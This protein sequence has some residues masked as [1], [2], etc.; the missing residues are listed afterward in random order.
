MNYVWIPPGHF[1][2]GC[3]NCSYDDEKPA[4]DVHLTKGFWLGQ[5]EV[6]Q[7]AYSRVMS[8]RPSYFT[9][10]DLPVEQVSWNEAEQYC[11]AI[12]GRL[13]TEA[14]WEYAAR[15]ATGGQTYGELG[16][17]AW[18]STNSGKTHPVAEKKPNDFGLYDM[19]GNVWEWTRDWYSEN[20]YSE[21]AN[22]DPQGPSNGTYRVLRGGSWY[23]IPSNVRASYRLRIVPGVRFDGIG[24]R[25]H[26]EQR[27][28]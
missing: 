25:C 8:K 23:Y 24:F 22:R 17:I 2:M 13:P 14:Q 18:Y 9:G 26:W 20:Y 3:D 6:T 7:R 1:T 28:P 21:S 27:F 11:Q 16:D 5:T 4:H 10:D 15:G 12:G 19:L